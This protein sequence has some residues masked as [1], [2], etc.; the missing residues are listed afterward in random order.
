MQTAIVPVTIFPAQANRLALRA[1]GFDNRPNYLASLQNFT[2][3]TEG[4]EEIAPTPET[5]ETLRAVNVE[6]TKAQWDN[7]PAG[8]TPELDEAYQLACACE[9]LGLTPA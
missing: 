6:M 8:D 5:V 4:T 2:P 9:N 1:V 7:W 3:A